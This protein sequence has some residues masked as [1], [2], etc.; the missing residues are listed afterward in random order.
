MGKVGEGRG[1]PAWHWYL[2]GG[3]VSLSIYTQ[4]PWES[5][6]KRRGGARHPRGGAQPG[7]KGGRAP[8][9]RG[10]FGVPE[11]CCAAPGGSRE[12][13][14]A[15][16][17]VVRESVFAWVGGDGAG[18]GFPHRPRLLTRPSSLGQHGVP[19]NLTQPLHGRRVARQGRGTACCVA[20]EC[21]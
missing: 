14:F 9:L 11:G 6:D 1:V 18:G 15:G 19:M 7:A 10:R 12:D 4:S 13:L 2:P 3:K 17:C 8:H 20:Q 16:V 5:R 21:C